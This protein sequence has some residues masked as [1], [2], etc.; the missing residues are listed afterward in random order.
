MLK[1]GLPVGAVKNALERDG[2]DPTIMD[3]DPNAPLPT[4]GA[5][6]GASHSSS[7][8]KREKA[9]PKDTHRR[10][11]LHWDTT[12]VAIKANSVWAMVDADD[13]LDALEIDEGE[14]A[15]LFQA[16]ISATAGNGAGAGGNR[17]NGGGG[18]K[19]VVQ[20]IDPKRANNGGIILARLRMSYDDMA[21]AVERM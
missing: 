7:K 9:P 13:S 21:R 8:T 18:K 6:A 16:E 11:R 17:G 14:F 5:S 4:T 10:T 1:L 20:V 2:L 3:L 19:G 12:G 15:N